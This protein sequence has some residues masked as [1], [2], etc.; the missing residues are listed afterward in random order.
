ML[1]D[2]RV[3]T[4]QR[5]HVES[6]PYF[7]NEE[8]LERNKTF[9]EDCESNV[10]QLKFT[11]LSALLDCVVNFVPNFSSSNLVDL[12]NFLDFRPQKG[13]CLSCILFVYVRFSP[14]KLLFI[15]KMII[16]M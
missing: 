10:L 12:V 7:T 11:F 15:T 4:T 14:N 2:A 13:G 9:F 1:E 16:S 3:E 6:H 8:H 5:G